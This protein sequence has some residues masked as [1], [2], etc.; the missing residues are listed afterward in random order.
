MYLQEESKKSTQD[1][2]WKEWGI[3]PK[4]GNTCLLRGCDGQR[5]PP[6]WARPIWKEMWLGLWLAEKPSRGPR[7]LP[8]A[9]PN[10]FL[11]LLEAGISVN[12]QK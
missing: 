6:H 3:G 9:P 8:P 10:M 12:K 4:N 11:Q 1:S 5:R 7:S 2:G